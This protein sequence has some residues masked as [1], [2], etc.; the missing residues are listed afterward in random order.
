[1]LLD[2]LPITLRDRLAEGVRSVFVLAVLAGPGQQRWLPGHRNHSHLSAPGP[3]P[4]P[5]V[6]VRLLHRTPIHPQG[7]VPSFDPE[8]LEGTDLLRLGRQPWQ[9]W[10]LQHVV[11]RKQAPE[12]NFQRSDPAVADVLGTQGPVDLPAEDPAHFLVLQAVLSGNP[13]ADQGLDKSEGL[14]AVFLEME[15]ELCPGE[16]AAA[17][18]TGQGNPFGFSSRPAQP[19]QFLLASLEMGNHAVTSICSRK[20]AS[21]AASIRLAFQY[22][23]A[24]ILM[25]PL[26]CK[27]AW[28]NWYRILKIEVVAPDF[29]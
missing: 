1:M 26:E 22:R 24:T 28:P 21:A 18:Q 3:Q 6:Q 27:L 14:P 7:Q 16:E 5:Q 10:M 25:Q 8:R 9:A 17:M 20:Q 2:R 19:L 15:A 29:R 12:E 23:S 13:L 4:P 11:E